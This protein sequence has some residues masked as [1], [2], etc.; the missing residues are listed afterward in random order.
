MSEPLAVWFASSLYAKSLGLPFVDRVLLLWLSR[1][2]LLGPHAEHAPTFVPEED[3]HV[4]PLPPTRPP[5]LY[6]RRSLTPAHHPYPPPH[7]AP[8]HAI[9]PRKGAKRRAASVAR[10]A[11]FTP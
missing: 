10:R 6:T 5:S 1:S 4:L 7:P 11:E 3:I 8:T 9:N 2:P